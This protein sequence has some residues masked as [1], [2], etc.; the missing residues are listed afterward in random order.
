[1]KCLIAAFICF[2]MVSACSNNAPPDKPKEV[3]EQMEQSTDKAA[4][5]EERGGEQPA[6]PQSNE[7]RAMK[8]SQVQIPEWSKNAV[9]YEVNVRQYTEEGTFQAFAEHLPRLKELGVDVLWF[10]PIHPISEKNR[11]GTLGSYYAI[12]DYKAVNPEYGTA[13][14]FK[15]L[16]DQAHEMGFKVLLDWVANHTGWDHVWTEEASWYTTDS[17]GQIVHPPGTN[18]LDVADLNFDNE[19]MKAA[20]IDAMKYWVSKYDIDGFRADYAN[21]VPVPFWEEARKQLEQIKPVYMLAEDDKVLE[22]LD[23][24]FNANY[25]WELYHITNDIAKGEKDAS[26]VKHHFTR[27]ERLYPEGTYPLNFITNHD[28]NSWTGTEFER[29]GDAVEAMAVLNF[30]V[31]GIPLIYSGQEAGLDKRLEFFEKDNISWDDLSMQSFYQDLIRLKKEN[32]ALWNGSSGGY[33]YFLETTDPKLLAFERTKNENTVLVIMN[34]SAAEIEGEVSTQ[35]IAGTY[36]SFTQGEMTAI[37]ERYAV[38]LGPWEY[39]I[40]VSP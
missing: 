24:S 13:E 5:Q 7:R 38:K 6:V 9:I 18:W 8:V 14:D 3:E 11:N 1:M 26:H 20:M 37:E 21:G 15:A 10:M 25:G 2:F 31:P 28:E 12:Q 36:R 40:Y 23:Q 16:V 32:E 39:R 19:E 4:N 29:L 17:E 35:S 22:L 30:T 27:V 33:I 34:L